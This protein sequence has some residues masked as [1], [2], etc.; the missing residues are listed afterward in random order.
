MQARL[1]ALGKAKVWKGGVGGGGSDP[2]HIPTPF[3][4][5]SRITNFCL[6][7]SEYC[8]LTQYCIRV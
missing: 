3:S 2:A 1:D 4:R 5:E 8:F 6:R 7:Y